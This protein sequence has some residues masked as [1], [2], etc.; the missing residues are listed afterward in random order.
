[1]SMARGVEDG[2]GP[3]RGVCG[4]EGGDGMQVVG[5]AWASGSEQGDLFGA[6]L[7]VS[8]GESWA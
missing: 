2:H 4:D 5:R 6:G 8:E 7:L 1:M 3:G